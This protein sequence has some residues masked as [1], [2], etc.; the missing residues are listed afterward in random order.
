MTIG[1][2]SAIGPRYSR[3][4]MASRINAGARIEVTPRRAAREREMAQGWRAALNRQVRIAR[5]I[6]EQDH[7]GWLE[8]SLAAA[9]IYFGLIWAVATLSPALVSA[10]LLAVLPPWGLGL[11][12][13]GQIG[14]G[15]GTLLNLGG[16]LRWRMSWAAAAFLLDWVLLG[17]LTTIAVFSFGT[18]LYAALILGT[19]VL[20]WRMQRRDAP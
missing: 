3:E 1:K 20:L 2:K 5:L 13:L 19:G 6:I 9:A 8:L 16:R 11:A 4:A 15:L 7:T 18:A 17:V 14:A 12:A 10:R